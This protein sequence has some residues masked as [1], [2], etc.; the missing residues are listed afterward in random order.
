M[1]PYLLLDK[2]DRCQT[3]TDIDGYFL[4]QVGSRFYFWFA[5][6]DD[7]PEFR[8]FAETYGNSLSI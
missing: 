6:A 3:V 4:E 7:A 8:I 1:V 5:C 2:M